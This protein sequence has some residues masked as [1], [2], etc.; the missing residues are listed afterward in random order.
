MI[1]VAGFAENLNNC[2]LFGQ[3]AGAQAHHYQKRKY[4]GK[5]FLH[6]VFLLT[7]LIMGDQPLIPPSMIPLMM[8]FWQAM[9]KTITGASAIHAAAISRFQRV[10]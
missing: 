4:Q 2:G 10:V 3:R 9:Y 1:G 7:I 8:N 6:I 5:Q